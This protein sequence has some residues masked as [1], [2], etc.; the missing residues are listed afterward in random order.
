MTHL[1][2]SAQPDPNGQLEREPSLRKV[3]VGSSV[4]SAAS[5]L[6]GE[7]SAGPNGSPPREVERLRNAH[8]PL[9]EPS[10]KLLT[11]PAA[12]V[13]A[14]DKLFLVGSSAY[15]WGRQWKSD[16]LLVFD[17]STDA[18]D[19]QSEVMRVVESVCPTQTPDR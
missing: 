5:M 3:P 9:P 7:R 13:S 16:L 11:S 2:G 14:E 10:P 4:I 17:S 8:P 1:P 6:R 12:A 18:K 19:P 15:V